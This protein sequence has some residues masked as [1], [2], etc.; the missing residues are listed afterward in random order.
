MKKLPRMLE[1]REHHRKRT[2]QSRVRGTRDN[3]QHHL[4]R[5]FRVGIIKKVVYEHRFRSK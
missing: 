5:V 3:Q 2:K 1:G 4:I